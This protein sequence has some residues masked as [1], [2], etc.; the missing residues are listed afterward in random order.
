ML[1][2]LL[3]SASAAFYWL[4]VPLLAQSVCKRHQRVGPSAWHDSM[5]SQAMKGIDIYWNGS[6]RGHAVYACTRTKYIDACSVRVQ[7]DENSLSHAVH[8]CNPMN[9]RRCMQWTHATRWIYPAACSARM[10]FDENTSLHAVHV[11]TSVML[12]E[13]TTMDEAYHRQRASS[14]A[15]QVKRGRVNIQP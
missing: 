7:S 8:A 6:T 12:T 11:C 2:S 1:L 4:H 5:H 3:A 10:H 14:I 9:I 13:Y 15:K